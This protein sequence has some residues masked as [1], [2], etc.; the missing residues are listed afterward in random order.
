MPPRGTLD[1]VLT[2]NQAYLDPE[3]IASLSLVSTAAQLKNTIVRSESLWTDLNT[4]I[5]N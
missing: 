3:R 5:D 2:L 1:A 4:F